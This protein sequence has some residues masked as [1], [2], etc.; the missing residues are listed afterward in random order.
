MAD[1]QIKEIAS[2]ETA[3]VLASKQVYVQKGNPEPVEERVTFGKALARYG[4][5]SLFQL[6]SLGGSV[7]VSSLRVGILMEITQLN[8][9]DKYLTGDLGITFTGSVEAMRWA[10]MAGFE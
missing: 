5:E 7:Y 2:E 8:L 9:I 3:M 6:I 4:P 10:A 1:D